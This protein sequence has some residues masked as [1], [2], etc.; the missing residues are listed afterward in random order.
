MVRPTSARTRIAAETLGEH[1][2][3][4]R[5][6]QG[7]TAAQVADRAGISRGT[8]RKVY[9]GELGVGLESFLNI[10]KVLGV[11][12]LLVE[13]LDPYETEL[14]RARADQALPQRVRP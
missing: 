11:L 5:K 4:W 14:G 9:T 2:L 3:A 8:L 12:D 10:T 13:A 7:M 6:L 1:L